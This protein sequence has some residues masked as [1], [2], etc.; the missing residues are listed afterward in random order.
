MQTVCYS[1]LQDHESVPRIS[2]L[3]GEHNV[4]KSRNDVDS[5][6]IMWQIY[7]CASDTRCMQSSASDVRDM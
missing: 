4:S 5:D 2:A 6:N 1:V 7:S 3:D